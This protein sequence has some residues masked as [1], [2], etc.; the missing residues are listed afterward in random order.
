M[1]Y[2]KHLLNYYSLREFD[3]KKLRQSKAGIV[4][5]KYMSKMIGGAE[6]IYH[7]AEPSAGHSTA[8][9][10]STRTRKTIKRHARAI[11]SLPT[12]DN[13]RIALAVG[14]RTGVKAWDILKKISIPEPWTIVVNSNSASEFGLDDKKISLRLEQNKKKTDN[15]N[16]NN[17]NNNAGDDRSSNFVCLQKGYLADEELSLLFYAADVLI[18]PYRPSSGSGVMFDGLGHGLPFIAT[19]LPFFKEFSSKG[20]GMA[21]K[22]KSVAFANALKN[23]DKDYNM[24]LREVNSFRRKLKWD[25]VAMQH[26][27]LYKKVLSSIA[28]S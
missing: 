26:I 19:N 14:F 12:D 13:N 20:L 11:F 5:S 15:N 10:A 1:E 6:L 9:E 25:L 17:N 4:F 23:I 3:R 24:Y 2:W 18:L 16:N 28:A 27:E 22:R 8:I 21:V 7:G